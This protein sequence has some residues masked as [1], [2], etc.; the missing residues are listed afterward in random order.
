MKRQTEQ[1]PEWVRIP[2]Q[3][4]YQ[5]FELASKQAEHIKANLLRDKERL[6]R[7]GTLLG[8]EAMPEH[9]EWKNWRVAVVDG[10]DS[11]VMTE[12]VGG[13]FGTYGATYHI[14]QGLDLVEEEYFSGHFSG[15]SDRR[16]RGKQE[17]A[18]TT[19]HKT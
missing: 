1:F 17:T 9:D 8:F 14:F 4:Q 15:L 5:F 10:S 6:A 18:V 13:R 3:M 12:R 2:S 7:L 11:P 19:D 16:Y